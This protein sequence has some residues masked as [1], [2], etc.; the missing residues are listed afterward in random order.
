[1]ATQNDVL[2]MMNVVMENTGMS[3][4]AAKKYA[5]KLLASMDT[6][7]TDVDT[8]AEVDTDTRV[9]IQKGK[10]GKPAVGRLAEMLED[11]V[12]SV[13]WYTKHR[14]KYEHIRLV[15]QWDFGFKFVWNADGKYHVVTTPSG[16]TYHLFTQYANNGVAGRKEFV[17]VS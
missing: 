15:L 11:G 13:E 14:I 8:N 3:K 9:A 1:M 12:E 2:S 6:S 10:N 7:T 5:K 4:K 17:L 16:N